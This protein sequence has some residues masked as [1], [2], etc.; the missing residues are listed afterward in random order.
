[1]INNA[2][3][4]ILKMNISFKIDAKESGSFEAILEAIDFDGIFIFCVHM[5]KQQNMAANRVGNCV[6]RVKFT[7][8]FKKKFGQL[9]N[10]LAISKVTSK[11]TLRS[12]SFAFSCIFM[13][14]HIHLNNETLKRRPFSMIHTTI[15]DINNCCIN[16]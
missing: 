6:Y 2:F 13:H 11:D 16:S 10:V 5:N 15:I 1:M 7:S 8:F 14:F 3:G 9:L 4:N 12:Q